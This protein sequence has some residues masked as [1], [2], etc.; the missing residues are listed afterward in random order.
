LKLQQTR[1]FISFVRSGFFTSVR[2][3]NE[4]AHVLL[5]LFVPLRDSVRGA[6]LPLVRNVQ[7]AQEVA[8]RGTRLFTF[9]ARPRAIFFVVEVQKSK[10]GGER[11]ALVLLIL[12][13]ML[14]LVAPTILA[15]LA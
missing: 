5:V 7:M 2:E 12:C 8:L 1:S 6:I 14:C 13:E 3:S 4:T 10:S 15:L 11:R 9:E